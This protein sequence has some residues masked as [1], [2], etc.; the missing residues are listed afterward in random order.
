MLVSFHTDIPKATMYELQSNTGME[1]KIG[2]LLQ[3]AQW[4]G[5]GMRHTALKLG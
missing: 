2:V 3:V 4:S 1:R 5:D